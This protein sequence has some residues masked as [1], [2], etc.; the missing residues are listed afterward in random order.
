MSR[1]RSKQYKKYI[2]EGSFLAIDP[3]SGKTSAAGWALFKGGILM[4]AGIIEVCS[5]SAKQH[6]LKALLKKLQERFD[7][8]D[9]LVIENIEGRMA[10]KVLI[11][12]CG[13][14]IAGIESKVYFEMNIR[15]WQS[16][17]EKLGGWKKTNKAGKVRGDPDGNEGDEY[18]AMYIG[19]AAIA[20]ALGYDTRQKAAE[21]EPFIDKTRE[22]M[23]GK[24]NNG[25]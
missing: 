3:S 18:D 10:P 25:V 1:T 12:A 16:I 9:L 5:V 24:G 14:F 11:Q 4:E 22:R 7:L 8:V 6:R 21:R 15:T 23:N 13:V 20:L 2:L 17:A 19:W